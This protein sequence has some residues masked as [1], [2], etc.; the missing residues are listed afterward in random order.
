MKLLRPLVSSVDQLA[1]GSEDL[2]HRDH[3][4]ADIVAAGGL[5]VVERVDAWTARNAGPQSMVARRI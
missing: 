3:L 2:L 5:A 4:H 1:N